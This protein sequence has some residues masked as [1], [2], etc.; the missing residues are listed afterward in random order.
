M[1]NMNE[2]ISP[3]LNELDQIVST[4]KAKAASA[5]DLVARKAAAQIQLE[6]ARLRL[7]EDPSP[8]TADEYTEAWGYLQSAGAVAQALEDGEA[9]NVKSTL[10]AMLSTPHAFALFA[11]AWSQRASNLE[12][13][14]RT[15]IARLADARHLVS[16]RGELNPL[17]IEHD[18]SVSTF[19]DAVNR[20]D[21][22]LA[23]ARFGQRYC[24]ALGIGHESQNMDAM[25]DATRRVLPLVP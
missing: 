3:E 12:A 13:L 23:E 5:R 1:S 6:H 8:A 25:L 20:I 16:A 24:E 9:T 19:R 11:S 17:V 10:Q 18:A 15:A 4:A 7:I 22:L 21:G 14:R 2:I